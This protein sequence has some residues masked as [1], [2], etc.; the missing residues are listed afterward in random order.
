MKHDRI[1]LFNEVTDKD[2]PN[3]LNKFLAIMDYHYPKYVMVYNILNENNLLDD[4]DRITCDI[5]TK[6]SVIFN[7]YLKEKEYIFYWEQYESNRFLATVK[8]ESR[9]LITIQIKKR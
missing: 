2:I 4:I 7:L 8:Q 1:T 6:N 9:E 5:L 3:S